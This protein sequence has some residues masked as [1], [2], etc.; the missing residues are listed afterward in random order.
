MSKEVAKNQANIVDKVHNKI[1]VL[2]T[3]GDLNL[4]KN[5]SP[6]NAL[7]SAFLILSELKDSNKKP[8]LE[9]CSQSS[10]ANALLDMV[11]KGLSPFK[12]QGYFIAYAG[13]LQFQESYLGKIARCKRDSGLKT[14]TSQA[15]YANDKF[16]FS[17]NPETGIKEITEHKQTLQ[18]LSSK[19][20]GAYAIL[21]FKDGSEYVEIMNIEQIEKSWNM[22]QG[23]GL[24]KAHT[25]FSDEMA[26]KTV[27]N[28]ACKVF[29][30][31]SDD[32]EILADDKP[33]IELQKEVSENANKEIIDFEEAEIV[34]TE[35]KI[36]GP[37][38][39]ESI[40][41]EVSETKSPY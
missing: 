14:I 18:S 11:V 8:V 9:S 35:T 37:E 38:S 12:N 1:K 36:N 30:N 20:I 34:E 4:S 32:S 40:T 25:Q 19:V 39:S 16:E 17:V 27:I 29:L 41:E 28:R 26:K 6:A 2:E 33:K 24:S 31:T 15:I 7:K 13:K 21:K 22:R 23:N 3:S 10:I 5:Y